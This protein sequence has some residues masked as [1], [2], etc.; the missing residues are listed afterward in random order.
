MATPKCVH[1]WRLRQREMIKTAKR[2]TFHG[3]HIKHRETGIQWRVD[4]EFL[5]HGYYQISRSYYVEATNREY[6]KRLV[7]S[8]ETMRKN[9]VDVV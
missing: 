7:I 6:V 2:A 8:H 3:K 4:F 1:D 5:G 9:Y